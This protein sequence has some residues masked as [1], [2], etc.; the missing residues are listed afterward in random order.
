MKVVSA[1]TFEP[2][3]CRAGVPND[4][5]GLGPACELPFLASVDSAGTDHSRTPIA[6]ARH[7]RRLGK[8]TLGRSSWSSSGKQIQQQCNRGT[9]RQWS[10]CLLQFAGPRGNAGKCDFNHKYYGTRIAKSKRMVR[11]LFA[12]L[13][14]EKW[15]KIRTARRQLRRKTQYLI[16][17][18]EIGPRV[19]EPLRSTGCSSPQ[20]SPLSRQE[21]VP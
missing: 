20:L 7:G 14:A 1:W 13:A 4:A 9:R 3:T 18:A 16:D 17:R 12:W 10:S 11:R 6:D 8:R 15:G 2:A 21:I 5:P 19:C